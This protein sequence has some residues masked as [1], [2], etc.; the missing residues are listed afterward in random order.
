MKGLFILHTESGMLLF[1]C[2]YWKN[3]GFPTP[4]NRSHNPMQ[5]ASLL[6][7]IFK[8]SVSISKRRDKG[9]GMCG[10]VNGLHYAIHGDIGLHFFEHRSEHGGT[11]TIVVTGTDF[12]TALASQ[13][14]REIS[15]SFC[16]LDQVQSPLSNHSTLEMAILRTV[17]M[18]ACQ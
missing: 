18:P 8:L 4:E 3:F 17:P 7:A 15:N 6:F 12:D 14:T 10:P 9:T 11:L 13:F 1:C 5:L 16:S 2:K